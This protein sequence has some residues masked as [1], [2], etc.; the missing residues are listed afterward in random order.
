[1]DPAAMRRRIR[2]ELLALLALWACCPYLAGCRKPPPS[3]AEVQPYRIAVQAYLQQH[4]MGLRVA[5]FRELEVRGDRATAV[6]ALQDAEGVVGV[7]V[8]WAFELERRNGRWVA[9]SH[10][11]R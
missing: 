7:K 6:V 10:R 4:S 2:P 1:M 11:E 8:R 9:V 5:G 3:S